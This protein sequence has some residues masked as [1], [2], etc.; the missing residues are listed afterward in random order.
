M[1]E[2]ISNIVG[3]IGGAVSSI[4]LPLIGAFMFHDSRK[5]KMDA[6]AKKLEID[7]LTSYA[8]EWKELYEQRDKRVD[9]LNAK[10]DRLYKDIEEDRTR[11]RELNEKNAALG[12][13]NLSLK[14][15]ECMVRGCGNRKPPSDY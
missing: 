5:R 4:A 9:E 10:I 8:D 11:I 12:Q 7:N 13:E 6:E 15:K 3:M 1:T 14:I 2:H